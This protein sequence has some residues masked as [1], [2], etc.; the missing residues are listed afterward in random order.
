MSTQSATHIG[1]AETYAPPFLVTSGGPFPIGAARPADG[2]RAFAGLD[3]PALA[4]GQA[5]LELG[6]ERGGTGEE[7]GKANGLG[8]PAGLAERGNA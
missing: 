1:E 5:A 6:C 7:A 3:T 8:R 2:A 4:A